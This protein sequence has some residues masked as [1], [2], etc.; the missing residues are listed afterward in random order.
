MSSWSAA[1]AVDLLSPSQEMPAGVFVVRVYYQSIEDINGL[2]EYD[3]WEYNNLKEKYVL[4]ALDRAGYDRLIAAGWQ[5]DLD[6][7]ATALMHR[8]TAA[9]SYFDQYRGDRSPDLDRTG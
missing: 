3:L 5:V 7:T 9:S 4:V 6:E 2:V 1:A 8:P